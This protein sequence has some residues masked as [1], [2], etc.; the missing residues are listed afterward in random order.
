MDLVKLY[1]SQIEKTRICQGAQRV[2][3]NILVL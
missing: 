1:S 2:E 3:S